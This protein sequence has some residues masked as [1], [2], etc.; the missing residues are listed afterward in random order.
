MGRFWGVYGCRTC[1]AA[2]ILFHD[3]PRGN[4]LKTEFR[5]ELTQV[6]KAHSTKIKRMRIPG[7]NGGLYL[8]S[9]A[10]I[11]AIGDFMYRKM[12]RLMREPDVTCMYPTDEI[13]LE[14]GDDSFS[15]A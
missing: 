6:L 9:H 13:D 7:P 5:A 1:M 12:A 11:R 4:Q 3:T 14:V 8:G 15:A 2:S 10:A